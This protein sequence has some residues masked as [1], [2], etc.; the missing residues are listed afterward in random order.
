MR[1]ETITVETPDGPM[2]LY[3][4]V[5]DD[6]RGAMVVIQEAFG[7]NSHIEE[8]TRRLAE[9]GYHSVAPHMF[10][11]T[12]DP[13]IPYAD[14]TP[15]IE[16]MSA[17]RDELILAD[18]DAAVAHLA[19]AGF[20]AGRTGIIGFCFGGRVTFLTAVNR[21]AGRVSAGAP[22]PPTSPESFR[23]SGRPPAVAIA[24]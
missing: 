8:V 6:P 21:G 2:A 5:P 3:E 16:H 20:D 9:Q 7:V 4:A 22:T 10:H 23:R 15:V 1:A 12:G 18:V 13:V 17:L 19:N 24:T 11:R 14:F